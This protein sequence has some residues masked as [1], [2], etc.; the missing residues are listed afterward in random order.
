MDVQEIYRGS[1]ALTNVSKIYKGTSL[2][3][4]RSGGYD[5]ATQALLDQATT[6]GYTAASG[7]VLTALDA[8]ITDLKD[9]GIWTLLDALWLPATNGDSDFG[10]YNLKDPTD[11]NLSKVNSPTFTSL[12]G[13]TG[14]G[15][16]SYLS[17]GFNLATDAVNFTQN[18]ASAGGYFR[19]T[20]STPSTPYLIRA[21]SNI[22]WRYDT[23]GNR[24]QWKFN[25]TGAVNH[26][27]S[28]QTGFY[29]LNRTASNAERVYR[30]G[31]TFD[32]GTKASAAISGTLTFLQYADAQ[33]SFGF[34][35]GNLS[36]K[37][38]ELYTA[39]QDYMT[40]LGTQV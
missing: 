18:A 27:A 38:S 22:Y 21:G 33:F 39:I 28:Q 5:V 15:S 26:S 20:A 29:H 23:G 30:N 7:T 24:Y 35:G 8:F 12:Q 2:L 6:D 14:N 34:V 4:E 9:D 31:T 25:T 10:C 32:T 17:T 3:F 19:T 37:V 36:T 11:N 1:S 13:F 16:T 40:A